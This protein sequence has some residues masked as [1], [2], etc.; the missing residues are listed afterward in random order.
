MIN[1]YVCVRCIR[2][3]NKLTT[4]RINC[5]KE[6]NARRNGIVHTSIYNTPVLGIYS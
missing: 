5:E 1:I 2:V 3:K 6:K 4:A